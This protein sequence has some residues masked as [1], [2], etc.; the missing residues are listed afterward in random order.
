MKKA[1]TVDAE[2]DSKLNIQGKHVSIAHT[3]YYMYVLKRS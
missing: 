3:L 2:T 1:K